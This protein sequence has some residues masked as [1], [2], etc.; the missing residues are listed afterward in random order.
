VCGWRV[1]VDARNESGHDGGAGGRGMSL[2]VGVGRPRPAVGG[3]GGGLGVNGGRS[4]ERPTPTRRW[5]ADLPLAGGGGTGRR[6]FSP[7]SVI[8]G[9]V[10]AIHWRRRCGGRLKT[11]DVSCISSSRE[12]EGQNGF[13][14]TT[15]REL[16]IPSPCK[17]EGQGGGRKAAGLPLVP[18]QL[19]FRVN[20]GRSGE[21]PTPTR[22][23][24][25]DLPLAG[26]G[27]IKR[28]FPPPPVIALAGRGLLTATG[29]VM[30]AH[31]ARHA[32]GVCETL[33][34]MPAV[35]KTRP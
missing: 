21:R 6:I 27:V 12:G 35:R 2:R 10:P 20:G 8:A 25:A 9:L 18:P 33:R 32:S 7:P 28:A 34:A 31:D 14:V 22:R 11:R 15:G 29:T 4:V 30:P 3:V 17:G 19:R 23:W 16:S 26:G 24:R 13:A 1:A 5:R